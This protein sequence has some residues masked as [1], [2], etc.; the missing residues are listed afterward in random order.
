[1]EYDTCKL[2]SALRRSSQLG[3]EVLHRAQRRVQ[4]ST[5]GSRGIEES[6]I[7]KEKGETEFP[8]INE[9][10]ASLLHCMACSTRRCRHYYKTVPICKREEIEENHI[11]RY[12]ADLKYH[13]NSPSCKAP[14]K[15]TD[16]VH[17]QVAPGSYAVTGK[18]RSS[19]REQTH[20]IHL[21]PDQTIDLI[22]NV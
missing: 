4:R 22:F 20:V 16:K 12:H 1:M 2:Q 18:S 14:I 10:F 3:Q 9:A 19:L 5:D 11:Q 8:D 15:S 13:K 7:Q 17:I 21:G 6:S